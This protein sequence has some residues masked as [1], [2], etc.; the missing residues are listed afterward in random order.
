MFISEGNL[1]LT[2]RF[3]KVEFG[4]TIFLK[5]WKLLWRFLSKIT[6]MAPIESWFFTIVNSKFTKLQFWF[7]YFSFEKSMLILICFYVPTPTLLVFYLQHI[8]YV[9]R[10]WFEIVVAI[11]L[12]IFFFEVIYFDFEYLNWYCEWYNGYYLLHQRECAAYVLS[13]YN[14]MV[15]H[16]KRPSIE[17]IK[18]AGEDGVHYLWVTYLV[19]NLLK[20]GGGMV[21]H[22][23]E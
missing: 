12:F 1:H 23:Y 8:I 19:H 18:K 17:R 4:P 2:S 9:S 11:E 6:L 16:E 7:K 20:S 13:T 14:F 10:Y 5:L 22:T 21:Y 3:C 15:N